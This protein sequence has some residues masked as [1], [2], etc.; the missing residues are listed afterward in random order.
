MA[1]GPK[2]AVPSGVAPLPNDKFREAQGPP[3]S[4]P[5][6]PWNKRPGSAP[7]QHQHREAHTR[8]GEGLVPLKLP[9]GEPHKRTEV[10]DQ[11][12]PV[13]RFLKE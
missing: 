9:G 1:Q 6:D 12:I 13:T 8:I 10:T 3:V 5:S 4:H 7:P 11:A 2:K